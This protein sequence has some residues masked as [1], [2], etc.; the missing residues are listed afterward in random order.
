MATVV[1]FYGSMA[2]FAIVLM[3]RVAGFLRAPVHLRWE[4]HR[5]DRAYHP[6]G[7]PSASGKLAAAAADVLFLRGFLRRPPGLWLTL[8][9]FH[10]G[11]YLLIVWH[12]WIFASAITGAR[13]DPPLVLLFGHTATALAFTGGTGILL[14]RIFDKGMRDYYSPFHYLKWL[15]VLAIL[16]QGFFVVYSHFGNSIPQVIAYV[17]K[18]LAFDWAYKL[19][20]PP[21]TS[22][23]VLLV[24]ALLVYLPFGHL[25]GLFFRYYHELRW[26]YV[27][28]TRG[29]EVQRTMYVNLD[30]PVSWAAG[31]IGPGR[32]WAGV[33]AHKP[34][35]NGAKT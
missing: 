1:I 16:A 24:S 18:Q 29:S 34:P 6:A 33:V 7:A 35:A 8:Y 22:L 14:R 12:A 3:V 25:A 32:T 13:L 5:Q 31:H 28:N 10:L 17:Q 21:E 27:P 4:I 2:F 30:R 15:L 11:V 23:H 9:A 19:H 26:D 20:S